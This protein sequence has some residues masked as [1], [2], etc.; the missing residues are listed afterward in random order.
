LFRS[1]ELST[2]TVTEDAFVPKVTLDWA[3]NDSLLLYG[4]YSQA[5]KPGGVSTTDS[6]GDVSD[7]E[8]KSEK[9]D[10]YEL[11]FKADF[12]D[13]SIRWNGA[14]FFY[15]YTDQQVPFQFLSPLTGQFQTSI[16]NAGKTEIKGFET[17]LVWNS[18]F[19]EGLS[20]QL[21]YTFTDAEFTDFNLA[22]ILAPLGGTASTFNRAK[23]G[24]ED[25]DFTGK[26][27]PLT[28]EN[29]ATASIRYDANFQNGTSTFVELFAK[30]QDQRF[31]SE[32]NRSWLPAYTLLDLYAGLERNRW[33]FT[34]FVQNLADDDKIKSG[35][36]NVDFTLLPDGRSL[37]QAFQLYLPQPRTF[38]ARFQVNFGE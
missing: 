27:P 10:A 5:F 19:L 3:V 30:Y 14:A 25:G 17:D 33:A 35:L 38:G 37:P 34:L 24:N 15:D 20:V 9:L 22:K 29:A 13:R 26:T 31:V 16:V 4:Y 28:P 12:R 1:G 7:G 2:N 36:G 8:Y 23:A 6:N 21:S 32:G 18:A 11:G